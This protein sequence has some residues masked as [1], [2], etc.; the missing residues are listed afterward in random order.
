MKHR[1]D[2]QK[3]IFRDYFNIFVNYFHSQLRVKNFETYYI[4]SKAKKV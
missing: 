3:R 1:N 4:I 2:P